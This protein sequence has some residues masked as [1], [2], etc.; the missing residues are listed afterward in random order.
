MSELWNKNIW[1]RGLKKTVVGMKFKKGIFRAVV[2][3]IWF[4]FWIGVVFATL[5]LFG[6]LSAFDF[7]IS[8]TIFVGG[9]YLPAMVI[10]C[11]NSAYPL[12]EQVFDSESISF[13]SVFIISA[14]AGVI[15]FAIF[16]HK[17]SYISWRLLVC[18]PVLFFMLIFGSYVFVCWIARGFRDTP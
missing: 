1:V 8:L 3:L 17:G 6:Q 13:K 10:M 11:M 7:L 2:L 14:I 9:F 4:L 18:S 12:R 15:G 16:V 5:P